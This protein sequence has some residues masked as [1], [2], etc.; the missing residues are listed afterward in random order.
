MENELMRYP[1]TSFRNTRHGAVAVQVV[2]S[3]TVLLGMLAIVLDGGLLM[4]Y[5][6]QTQAAADAAALAYAVT[7]ATPGK[8]TAQAQ[9]SA[10]AI[11]AA[12]G[13]GNDGT[14]SLITPNTTA[15]GTPLHGIWNGPVS[16]NFVGKAGTK[17]YA[18]GY[19]EV[20]IEYDEPRLFSAIWGS[21]TLPVRGRAVACWG[22]SP[23]N[24]WSAS[25]LTLNAA[26]TNDVTD[27]GNG[28]LTVPNSI[29]ANAS[30][31][32]SGKNASITS[33]GGVIQYGPTASASGNI[34]PSPTQEPTLTADPLASLALPNP[35]GM[36]VQSSSAKT[37]TS[38]V[39]LQP[40]L[41]QGGLNI[42]GGTVTL[43]PGIYYIEGGGLSLSGQATVTDN[44]Q[45]VLIFNGES[46]GGT[47]NPGSV[48]AFSIT[49]QANLSITPMS[50]GPWQGIS[51]FQDRGATAAL[52]LAGNGNINI[53][54]LVY[55]P[56][57]TAT[58]A[59]NGVIGGSTSFITY[60]LTVTGNGTFTPPTIKVPLPG[61]GSVSGVWLVE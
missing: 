21:G 41:Y 32:T 34:S 8:T 51:F 3:L 14:Y 59:G 49:G 33:T 38:S 20:V 42:T 54:G 23:A 25:V 39:T 40:G 29:I 12:N 1:P 60:Q 35:S 31:T 22:G 43:S 45:G 26:K 55:A 15:G 10:L 2:L 18:T 17:G 58:L 6:R 56:N 46:N 11:A 52:N 16:G 61:S 47:S 37:I 4:A 19:V 5:K 28:K 44:G 13:A 50:S 53:G 27:S 30:I 24:Y 7:M 9:A 57:A 48:G 36:T